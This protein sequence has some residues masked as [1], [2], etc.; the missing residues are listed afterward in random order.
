MVKII[1]AAIKKKGIVFTGVRHG[2]IIRQ[3]LD[4]GFLVDPEA[5]YVT[6]GEQGFIDSNN[7]FLDREYAKLVA[8][9][10]QQIDSTHKGLL[11]SEDLW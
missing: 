1:A 4:L 6:Q 10:A 8:L 9:D 5:D 2:Q 3:M 11:Y 7:V